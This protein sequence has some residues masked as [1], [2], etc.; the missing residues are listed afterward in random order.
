MVRTDVAPFGDHDS[1]EIPRQST[2]FIVISPCRDHRDG[3]CMAAAAAC[4]A[5]DHLIATR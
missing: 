1:A 3:T 5:A 4:V 2:S